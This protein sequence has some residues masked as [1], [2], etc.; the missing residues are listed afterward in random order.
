MGEV[1]FTAAWKGDGC[2]ESDNP[3]P[4]ARSLNNREKDV[5]LLEDEMEGLNRC[6][7]YLAKAMAA[8]KWHP[9]SSIVK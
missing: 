7:P 6:S 1:C 4:G 3:H 9:S 8:Q 5:Q 2:L